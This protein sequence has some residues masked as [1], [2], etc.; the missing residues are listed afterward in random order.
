MVKVVLSLDPYGVLDFYEE[1][2]KKLAQ[3]QTIMTL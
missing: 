2:Y 1:E 3:M